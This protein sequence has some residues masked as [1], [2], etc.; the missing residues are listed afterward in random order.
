MNKVSF[1]SLCLIVFFVCN[2]T[3][4]KKLKTLNFQK[5][6][7]LDILLISR[8]ENS[9]EAYKRYRKEVIPVG[10]KYGFQLQPGFRVSKLVRGNNAP[11]IFLFGK[12]TNI[13]K[14]VEFLK[15]IVSEVTD[16]HQQRRGLFKRF[17]LAYYKI[18]KDLSF[19]IDKSKF[20]VVTSFWNNAN[21]RSNAFVKKWLTDVTQTNGNLI[22]KLVDG[23]S[24]TGYYYNPD[25]LLIVEW[26]DEES[27]NTFLTKYPLDS[28]NELKNIQQFVI[29]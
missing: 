2:T 13:E 8:N 24:P 18:E 6:E 17:N 10:F 29:D 1:F 11:S 21:K 3:A 16:F 7:V 4:Q 14:R 9:E 15:N 23:N 27:F 22:L 28:Y 12:W 26:P 25:T 19:T 5:G 20:N